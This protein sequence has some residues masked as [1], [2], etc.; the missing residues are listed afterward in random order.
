M[1]ACSS[2]DSGKIEKLEGSNYASWKFN[3]KLLLMKEDLYGFIDGTESPPVA[4]DNDKKEKE[5]KLYKSRSQKAFSIIALS[6]SKSLQVHIRNTVCP[7]TAW[8]TLKSHFEFVSV[9]HIVRVY[10]QFYAAE[11][12]ESTDLLEHITHMTAMAE[13]LRELNEDVSDKK[14]AVVVL[15]SL[16]ESYDVFKTT[17]NARDANTLT[18][19]DTKSALTEYYMSMKDKGE[20]NKRTEDAYLAAERH[21]A[22]FT[23]G[24]FSRGGTQRGFR[25]GR[26]GGRI[27]NQ[28][29]R[30]FDNSQSANSQPL[31]ARGRGRGGGRGGSFHQ[32]D[33][34]RCGEL[35][36]ISAHCPQQRQQHHQQQGH[37][38]ANIAEE[39]AD[40][41][42]NKRVKLEGDGD[43]IFLESDV[44]L[45]TTSE[46]V[47]EDSNADDWFV[48]SAASAHMTYNTSNLLQYIEYEEPRKVFLGNDMFISAAGE[49]KIRLPIIDSDKVIVLA[50]SKVLFV[51]DLAKNLLSVRSMTEKGAEI[52]FNNKSCKVICP[53]NSS[54]CIANAF[55][56]LYK[57]NLSK[58]HAVNYSSVIPDQSEVIYDNGSVDEPCQQ[59]WHARLGH[60]NQKYMQDMISNKLASGMIVQGTSTYLDCEACTQ[61]KM[62]RSSFPKTS[63][64]RASKPLELVH[65]DL[66][67]PMQV[68]SSGGSRYMLTF[69]DD[70]SRYT[71]VCFLKKKSEVLQKF[72]QFV[73]YGENMF[74]SRVEKLSIYGN[75]LKS[76]RTDNGGE[77]TSKEFS[78]FCADKGIIH[79]FTNP[80]TPEQNGVAERL[81]RTII[82]AV[83][84]MIIHAKLPLFLWAE[85]VSTAVYIH[86]RCPTAALKDGT[87]YEYWFGRKPDLSN[88]R[89]FG[90]VAYY[91]VPDKQRKKLDPKSRRAV[92]VGYPVGT[93]GYK[94]YDVDTGDFVR[95]RN[96]KFYESKYHDFNNNTKTS[97]D[98]TTKTNIEF[99]KYAIF[100]SEKLNSDVYINKPSLTSTDLNK[101][102][103]ENENEML[104][105]ATND[106][107][108]QGR[109]MANTPVPHLEPNVDN[110]GNPVDENIN[111][112]IPLGKQVDTLAPAPVID[113]QTVCK[114][115]EETFMKQVESLG[116]KRER[117]TR[118]RLIEADECNLV[119]S[120]TSGINEPKS[121][122]EA[123]QGKHSSQWE[124]AIQAEYNSLSENKTWDLVPRP[125]NTNVVGC[126]WVFKVKRKSDGEIDRFKAR[127][128]AQG[129]TQKH[130]VDYQEVFSPVARSATIRSLLALAN[131]HDLEIHQMDV[132]TAFLN[133]ELDHDIYMEQPEGYIDPQHP[134]YVCKLNKSLYGLK[135]SARLWNGTLDAYLEESGYRSCGSDSC[136]YVKTRNNPNGK[137]SFVILAVFVDDIIPVANDLEMLCTEK[138]LF[139][140]R[141]D[142]IDR[143]EIHDVLGLLITRDR[144]NKCMYVSQPD[145]VKNILVRFRMENCNPV[146]TPLE[147]GKQFYKFSEG[148]ELFDKQ[149]YQQAI[150]CLTY[151]SI[152]TRPD[153]S[154]AVGALSQYMTCP[155]EEHWKGIKRILRYLKGTI[156]YG[157]VFTSDG[158]NILY[159]YSDADWA[160]DL[161]TRRSTSG[162]VFK[163]GGAIVS[164]NSKKQITVAKSTTE[165]EYV[166]LSAAA[167]ETI[168]LRQL[169]KD[170]GFN[171]S[172]AT[173][174]Y[175][176]NNGAIELS[177]NAKHHGRTKHI[178][179][180]HHF[181]RERVASNELS[182]IHCPTG[183]MLA[184]VMTKGLARVQFEKLRNKLGVEPVR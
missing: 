129:F 28:R 10:R 92:F 35:G 174:L 141:F 94:L 110:V 149:I 123:L 125:S 26:G 139:S 142:M 59:L 75:N 122:N 95:S 68:D 181:I 12:T 104:N 126:R 124:E 134:D 175:E 70:Y 55:G 20:K 31:G 170:L 89:V 107:V 144:P 172:G 118:N 98:K 132:C 29:H 117:K 121:M 127:L 38:N 3:M 119:E 105:E 84:T 150:G 171:K 87:P 45:V 77:Y 90:C 116:G 14:F 97:G 169:L 159:G 63:N 34:W 57:V 100:P 182:V 130:G 27:G 1:E 66:C 32:K 30:N 60:V 111:N 82:E 40:D 154:A 113:D 16:P 62:H 42:N 41:R 155:T 61:G 47:V 164:W 24:G 44:A 163:I 173:V 96:I 19:A 108:E 147:A 37:E 93:K 73:A 120:L 161:D 74:N 157:L 166:A 15:G 48:D 115:Y 114:T 76:F 4:T 136:L 72:K 158:E 71:H 152:S 85:A 140:E 91:L 11:M 83:R 177:K 151:A 180:A 65:S 51:P 165:A 80:H 6:I 46:I 7:K 143:G 23:G 138:S 168:W 49:G 53:N 13:E 18:W 79:E 86:N 112:H 50:L 39:R 176:D 17:L 69:I 25:G 160:G 36:H 2:G 102:I 148:D 109:E 156:D 88:L 9:N 103:Y 21:D 78:T 5:I 128:V 106:G 101:E 54:F 43:N 137:L 52:V 56:N 146:S 99:G 178:D 8:D 162:Y 131:A 135:Q 167:S 22:Y 153:I 179:I 33:C 184:D 145:Y 183:D 64:H 58:D 67:G 133:G 81:N